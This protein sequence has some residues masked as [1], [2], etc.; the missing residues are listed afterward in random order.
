M[1]TMAENVTKKHF[2]ITD[3]TIVGQLFQ[4]KPHYFRI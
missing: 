3:Q 1:Q 4:G 2:P